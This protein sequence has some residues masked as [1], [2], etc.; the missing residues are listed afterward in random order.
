VLL[1]LAL[2]LLGL[3][4]LFR[5]SLLAV[6]PVLGCLLFM[7]PNLQLAWRLRKPVGS[8]ACEDVVD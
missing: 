1:P 3:V 8:G 6:G 5:G 4:L 2:A 7:L